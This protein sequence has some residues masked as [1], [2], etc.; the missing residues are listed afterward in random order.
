MWGSP[1]ASW[2]LGHLV[3]QLPRSVNGVGVSFH[4][5]SSLCILKFSLSQIMPV[6]FKL[7]WDMFPGN[8]VQILS[9]SCVNLSQ[10]LLNTIVTSDTCCGALVLSLAEEPM[11]RAF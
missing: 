10:L 1:C 7:D 4:S 6:K 11:L 5:F 9:L 2:Y 8:V 3:V